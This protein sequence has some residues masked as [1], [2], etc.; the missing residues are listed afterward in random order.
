MAFRFTNRF[1]TKKKG[2]APFG[3]APK[4]KKPR[5]SRRWASNLQNYKQKKPAVRFGAI[6]LSP[7]PLAGSIHMKKDF[8]SLNSS[9]TAIFSISILLF[10]SI[11]SI[12]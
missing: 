7:F 9:L 11:P 5:I 6:G 12:L 8:P 3:T 10:Q 1:G 4:T 2:A